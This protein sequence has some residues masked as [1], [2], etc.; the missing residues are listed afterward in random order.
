MKVYDPI[1]QDEVVIEPDYLVLSTGIVAPRE[2]NERLSKLF[3]VPLN[4][5]GFF[6]EAHMKLR[7]VEFATDGVFLCGLAHGPKTVE[8]SIAQAYAAVSRACT[9]L[10]KDGIEAVAT[11]AR[12]DERKCVGCG[13]CE[14]VCAYGAV[15]V[16]EKRGRRVAEVNP[17]LCKGCGACS[18]ACRSG[19]ID[20]RHFTDSEVVRQITSLAG[21]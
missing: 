4:Q 6:L 9:L 11:T 2:E 1:L 18:G 16:V 5:D 10:S 19:A 20:L 13:Y 15:S 7:P 14:M 21:V 17:A 8:E 3:K 12:V